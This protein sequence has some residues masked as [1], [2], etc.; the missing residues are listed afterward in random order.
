MTSRSPWPYYWMLLGSASFAV[1][2]VLASRLGDDCPWQWIAVAR[3]S[4]A[5]LFAVLLARAA[6]A[7]LVFFK[8][9]VL[10]MR[11]IAGSVSL[12]L[13]FFAMTHAPIS[14]VLTLTNMFPL[15]VAVLSWPLLGEHPPSEV[16]W[17]AA[18]GVAGVAVISQPLGTSAAW[19]LL[20]ATLSSFTSGVAMI[21]LHKL[22]G[23]DSRAI[24]A[25]FSAVALLFSL[26]AVCLSPADTAT[27]WSPRMALMLLG[28]GLSATAGQLCL[29]KAFSSGP[30]A[31][32]AV[33][34]LSQ[35]AFSMLLE[36][37]LAQRS[38]GGLTLLG[39]AL[40]MAPTAWV[41]LRSR[42]AEPEA[43]E[44]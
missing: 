36:M 17:A 3:T 42:K 5:M 10:W 37:A 25:H 33:V 28:I 8:P 15:W 26:S 23:I 16:W 13:G 7:P 32:V 1:M 9:R 34:G 40:V 2:A 19:P 43:L 18:V 44:G 39:M 35:V 21:G 29:T 4:L 14:E 31:R 30:P 11:S 20:A 24:V 41:M 38:F 22:Q 6:G 12:L 27:H